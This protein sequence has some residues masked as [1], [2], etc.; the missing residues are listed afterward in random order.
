M[1]WLKTRS[2]LEKRLLLCVLAVLLIVLAARGMYM[3]GRWRDAEPVERKT[4]QN[5]IASFE[6]LVEVLLNQADNDQEHIAF[7]ISQTETGMYCLNASSRR[8]DL[9]EQESQAARQVIKCLDG[10]MIHVYRDNICFSRE[11]SPYSIVYSLNGRRPTVIGDS[12]NQYSV[13]TRRIQGQWYHMLQWKTYVPEFISQ[14]TS[15]ED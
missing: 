13:K 8:I 2:S 10:D 9:S 6:T 1:Q 12:N 14:N 15:P 11:L 4:F 5:N 3:D 7:R